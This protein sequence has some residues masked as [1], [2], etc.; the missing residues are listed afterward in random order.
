M[1]CKCRLLPS[2]GFCRFTMQSYQPLTKQVQSVANE[3]DPSSHERAIERRQKKIVYQR[4]RL[5]KVLF[6]FI[7]SCCETKGIHRHVWKLVSSRLWIQK[8]ENYAIH[9]S[10][11]CFTVSPVFTLAQL[12]HAY[13]ITHLF[14][15]YHPFSA[16]FLGMNVMLILS[17][18]H[19]P[20]PETPLCQVYTESCEV[21]EKWEQL[22]TRKKLWINIK[23]IHK[24]TLY[25]LLL[26]WAGNH[27]FPSSLNIFLPSTL[28]HPDI[29]FFPS[30]WLRLNFFKL[31]LLVILHRS[32]LSRFSN[33]I[34]NISFFFFHVV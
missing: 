2:S 16:V 19:R 10:V 14:S 13:R 26:I 32:H 28:S 23:K 34:L 8:V 31:T 12:T 30:R 3:K 18:S 21:E 27:V 29:I 4:Q 17:F 22:C 33:W 15:F 25:I 7:S 1:L 20:I 6:F 11:H 5:K 24:L 9:T